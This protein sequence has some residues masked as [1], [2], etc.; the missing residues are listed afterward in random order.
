MDRQSDKK[1]EARRTAAATAASVLIHLALAA[2][3]AAMLPQTGPAE[4]R[5][6]IDLWM[7]APSVEQRNPG[8]A[9]SP[10][11]EKPEQQKPAEPAPETTPQPSPGEPGAPGP[12]NAGQDQSASSPALPDYYKQALQSRIAHA[13]KTYPETS[14]LRARREEGTVLVR[15]VI[16]PDGSVTS[17]EVAGTSGYPL[18]DRAAVEI[19]MNAAPFP[20][21]PPEY[22]ESSK[23][24]TVPLQFKLAGR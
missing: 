20:P 3:G 21:L 19:I 6:E 8:P 16:S 17:A 5:S 14:R 22:E 9:P 24:V 4:F 23:T 10:P 1:G 11:R 13:Q 15:F 2:A 12:E 18:L 7:T